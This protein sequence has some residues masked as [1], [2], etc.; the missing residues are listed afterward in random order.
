MSVTVCKVAFLRI[1][2][3]SNGRLD[4]VLRA[5]EKNFGSPCNDQRG[6]HHPANES[7]EVDLDLVN[8]HI[9]SL[10]QHQSDY[11]RAG[12]PHKIYLSLEL[13]ITKM[14][15]QYKEEWCPEK[16]TTA[17]SKWMYRQVYNTNFTLSFG[18]LENFHTYYVDLCN[19]FLNITNQCSL[20][21]L[22]LLILSLS[23]SHTHTHPYAYT[24]MHTHTHIRPHTHAHAHLRTHTHA[25]TRMH[26]RTHA[27]TPAHTQ[28]THTHTHTHKGPDLIHA[29]H[30]VS[31][32]YK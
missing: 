9:L 8:K 23:F 22:T 4:C 11:S 27:C 12:N 21:T 5:Q 30:A 29:R 3:I 14:Y 10:P 1:C 6:Q 19:I 18:R 26:S 13:T 7:S 17:V 31:L 32:K 2:S 24:Y 25:H 15:V 28:H 16:E 20:F